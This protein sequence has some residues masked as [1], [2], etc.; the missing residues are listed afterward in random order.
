MWNYQE[1]I[2]ERKPSIVVEF[3]SHLGGSALFF[4]H[5]L[6]AISPNSKVMTVD[7]TTNQIHKSVLADERIEV[8]G[9]ETTHPEV[10]RRIRQLRAEYPG[11]AFV[12]LDS[13]HR[14]EH[15]L[16]EMRALRP[17]LVAGDYLVV[18]DGNINGHPVLPNWGDGPHEAI[19]EYERC[20]QHDYLLDEQREGK[21]GFTFAPRGFLIR[22]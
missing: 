11:S 4:A 10:I 19:A 22:C 7:K 2:F 9:R 18:E 13:D 14:K 17:V 1:I 3:G 6:R 5:I 16:A 15:V 21:F 12:I 20:F 8:I